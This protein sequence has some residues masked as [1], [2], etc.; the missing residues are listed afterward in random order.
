MFSGSSLFINK[1]NIFHILLHFVGGILLSWAVTY[2]W[3]YKALWPI[4]LVCSVPTA[5]YEIGMLAAQRLGVAV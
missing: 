4:V 3:S 5:L 1:G 2:Q